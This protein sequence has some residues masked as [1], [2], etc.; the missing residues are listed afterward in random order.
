MIFQDPHSVKCDTCDH[1]GEYK[2]ALLLAYEAKCDQC[3][4][5][6]AS[7]SSQMNALTDRVKESFELLQVVLG[8]EEHF[9]QEYNGREIEDVQTIRDL[10]QVT[11]REFRNEKESVR[12]SLF[13][14]LNEMYNI[15]DIDL[16]APII[17]ALGID[18]EKRK[19]R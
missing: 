4:S 11:E 10:V 16:E 2:V 14:Y 6:F 18:I 7:A 3:G 15:Q 8:I 13:K 1:E 12:T 5:G 19:K 17:K 9:K